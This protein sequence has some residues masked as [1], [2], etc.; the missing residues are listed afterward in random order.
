MVMNE[1]WLCFQF[2]SFLAKFELN[3]PIG[4]TVKKK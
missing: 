3:H 2:F 1:G 4:S